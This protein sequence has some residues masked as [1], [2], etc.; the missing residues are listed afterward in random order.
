M[1]DSSNPRIIRSQR[2]RPRNS[3]A[4]NV[5]ELSAVVESVPSQP[6]S[7]PHLKNDGTDLEDAGP[8]EYQSQQTKVPLGIIKAEEELG[9][10]STRQVP[11]LDSKKGSI[12]NITHRSVP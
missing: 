1:A 9:Y 8:R 4:C 12:A 10:F 7:S 6:S 3:P 5:H 11:C 2:Y